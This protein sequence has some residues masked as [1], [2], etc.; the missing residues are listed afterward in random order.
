MEKSMKKFLMGLMCIGLLFTLTGCFD[1]NTKNSSKETVEQEED[2]NAVT[3]DDQVI[4]DLTFEHFAIV[5]DSD[6]ISIVYFDI[7]NN[8]ENSIDVGNIKFTLYT[9]GVEVTSLTEN[10]NKTLQPGESTSVVENYDVD[11]SNIDSVE[12]TVQ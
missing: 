8:T 4:G 6:N 5:Q 1:S 2:N 11:L 12:Y 10:I 3:F 9:S 7:T